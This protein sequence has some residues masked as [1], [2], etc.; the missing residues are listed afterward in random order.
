MSLWARGERGGVVVS[1]RNSELSV[2]AGLYVRQPT[3][4]AAFIP[5]ALPPNPH[6][7]L[8]AEILALIADAQH[9]IG[10]LDG[11]ASVIPAPD[12]FLYAFVRKEALLSSQIEGTQC[13]LEDVLSDEPPAPENVGDVEEVSNYVLAMKFGIE[14][15]ASLPISSRLIREIHARLMK[16]VRGSNKTPGE[17]RISQNWIGRPSATLQTADF[18][19]PPPHEVLQ[20]MGDLEKFIHNEESLPLIVKAGLVHAQFETIHPF[21]DGNGRVGRLLITL[22][23]CQW[24][25]LSQP[26]LYLSY[27]F[28]AH[29]TEYYHRLSRVRTHGE[30]EN[31]VKFFL[32][33]VAETAKS[34]SETGRE[35]VRLHERDRQKII[36][37]KPLPMMS[38]I[39]DKMCQMPIQSVSS[40]AGSM[41]TNAPTIQRALNRLLALGIVA[42]ITGHARNRRFAYVKYVE[43]LKEGTANEPG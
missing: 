6:L 21:L 16:G 14:R 35:I 8:D 37:S 43:L 42:E 29:R 4:Y 20:C 9:A 26:L 36:N 7:E 10:Q 22:L 25:L 30:W 33:G 17:Y 24:K 18:V 41:S 12:I 32:R 39:F 40:L 19:P 38:K 15:L 28:K 5:K 27:F 23:L 31:W 11:L 3:G 1:Q 34:A 2:R 13:S